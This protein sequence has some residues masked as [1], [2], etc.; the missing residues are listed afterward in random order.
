MLMCVCVY[1]P[2]SRQDFRLFLC[3]CVFVFQLGLGDMGVACLHYV[4]FQLVHP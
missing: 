2:S 4:S 1:L 3:F